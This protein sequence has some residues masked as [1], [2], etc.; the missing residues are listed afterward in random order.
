M[1]DER[2]QGVHNTDITPEMRMLFTALG[3]DTVKCFE[4]GRSNTIHALVWDNGCMWFVCP[5]CK[6]VESEG[7]GEHSS[8]L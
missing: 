3:V 1:S 5:S 6:K 2:I 7:R 8:P 4:C